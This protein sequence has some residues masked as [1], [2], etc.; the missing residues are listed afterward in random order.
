MLEHA[1]QKKILK[2]SKTLIETLLCFKRAGADGILTY[3]A[4][5]AAKEIIKLN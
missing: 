3:F 5:E 1:F 4:C 2:K